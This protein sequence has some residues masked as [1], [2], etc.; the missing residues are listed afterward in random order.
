M[1][2]LFKKPI[3]SSWLWEGS[4]VLVGAYLFFFPPMTYITSMAVAL[5][6]GL[7]LLLFRPLPAESLKTLGWGWVLFL[8]FSLASTFWSLSSGMTLQSTGLLFLGTLLY[9][10]ARSNDPAAQ[11]RLETLGMVL[12]AL[13]ALKGLHQWLFDFRDL[14]SLLG[15]MSGVQHDIVEAAVHNRRAFGFFATSGSLAAF[16]L[17]FLPQAFLE[18]KLQTGS[19]R[20]IY[21][22]LT[23]LLT[24]GL[25][26]TQSVGAIACL[27]LAV[28][29]VLVKRRSRAAIGSL[30]GGGALV[31]VF[32]IATR[33]LHSW[34][35]AA[36]GMRVEL[37]KAA[38]GLFLA[39]P[40]FGTGLGTFGELYQQVGL[41]MS[42]GALYP[43]NILLQLMVETGLAGLGL[44][45][46]ALYSLMARLKAPFRW[47][48][49][50]IGTGLL[51][52]FLFS[53]VDLPFQ[54]T[55]L[56]WFFAA[57]AGRLELRPAKSFSLPA[58]PFKCIEWG[59]L[60]VLG[61][62]GFWPPFRPWNLAL[63]ACVL[64]AGMAMGRKKVEDIPL[65]IALGG[66][67]FTLRAFFSPSALG[68]VWFLEIAGLLLAFVLLLR[69]LPEP[70]KFLE[71]FCW[72]G[73]FWALAVWGYSFKYSDIKYWA[74]FPNPK[75]VAIFLSAIFFL[76]FQKHLDLK[77]LLAGAWGKS[78]G[79]VNGVLLL[80]WAATAYCLKS[81]AAIVG[82]IV[83]SV[84]L[85]TRKQRVKWAVIG[86]LLIVGV[87]VIRVSVFRS[88][89]SNSTQWSRF[90]IWVS[91]AKV[92]VKAPFMGVGPGAFSG[93]YEQV[94]SPRTSGV[95]RFLMHAQ[96]AESEVLEVLMAFGLVGL[97]FVFFL[98][99]FLWPRD[100]AGKSAA[101]TAL[102]T[103]SAVS[104]C[105][106]TPLI[107]L[108]GAG[109]LVPA[110]KK[111]TPN[112]PDLVAGF[113]AAGL[114]LGLFASAAYAPALMREAD[115]LKEK[116]L[117]PEALRR[118]ETI[119]RLNAWDA[120][121]AAKK[122][123]FLESLYLAT[124]DMHWKGK[125]D[126]SFQKVLELEKTESDRR[127]ENARR[128]T[129]RLDI[130]PSVAAVREAN[131]AWVEAEQ[132]LPF[133][134]FVRMEEA[135]FDL[136]TGQEDK[137][138]TNFKKATELEPN[139]AKAWVDL[140]NLLIKQRSGEKAKEACRQALAVY[141]KWKDADRIDPVEK[142]MVSLPPE[143]LTALRKMAP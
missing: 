74:I 44:F 118:M 56:V 141:E 36:F 60:I 43:H 2:S 134:V 99:K 96:Y 9:L 114:A 70:D 139:D 86:L 25:L 112:K 140:G 61:I 87:L 121:V 58:I 84:V 26:A 57:L 5:G 95:N 75:Y 100:H 68:A 138:I 64:W 123:E 19:K 136:R 47:E 122:A 103:A 72:L 127:F 55:E 4:F 113:L 20:W 28:L 1:K 40:L 88:L 29:F 48:G 133:N 94:K 73:V 78:G 59:I 130:N 131:D 38:W 50:G 97:L 8:I 132:V 22:A 45:L 18:T 15:G 7:L 126:E 21:R 104:F 42:T 63:V 52:F 71:K 83:G 14:Q 65:W 30:L 117:F 27:I 105:L 77:E 89:E 17:L 24:V 37:W 102:G 66:V 91:A 6:W 46:L 124:K 125:S 23:L 137:A 67:F 108:Q 49:W 143:T 119:E 85:I 13:A 32:L 3:P 135:F 101:L 109:L 107:A 106:H 41:P 11:K 90:G 33:G 116:G 53:L 35:L 142:E 82:A 110:E 98:L 54:M 115:S 129:R 81:F 80:F 92:W 79:L 120:R 31:V 111:N 93:Y 128:L 62:S 39:H 51:A 10:M 69:A 16:L 34:L 12:A 76:R